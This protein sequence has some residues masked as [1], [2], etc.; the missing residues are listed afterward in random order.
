[1]LEHVLADSTLSRRPTSALI[2]LD[3]LRH[4]LS[5][6][7]KLIGP[8][9]KVMGIVK[10]NAYGH[11]LVPTAKALVEFGVNQLGVAFLEEGIALRRSGIKVP[12][13]VLGG[14]IG[15][16]VRHFIEHDL[17][18]AAASPYKVHQIDETARAMGTQAKVHLKVDT[19][20]ERLGV[21]WDNV[22]VLLDA[23]AQAKNVKVVGVFSHLVESEDLNSDYTKIQLERFH[24]ALSIVKQGGMSDVSVHLANSGGLLYHPDTWFDM[25]RPGLALYGVTPRKEDSELRLVLKLTSSIVYFKVI[26]EGS[27]VSY[28]RSWTAKETTRIVT[29]PIGYGDGYMRSMSNKASVIIRGK[30]C[31]VVG[32][33]TMDASMVNLGP[34]GTGYNGDNVIL[35]GEDSKN[36][37]RVSIHEL[38][39]WANTIPYEILTSIN[40]RVPRIY[41]KN[42]SL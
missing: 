37:T 33:I 32:K 10:A 14:L 40:T 41:L 16:Q 2:Q 13:L 7:K 12:I 9:R 30:R 25:V 27:S 21:H 36:G 18:M 31:P 4:N 15:N 19:G 5:C 1:M 24:K 34:N 29:I 23:I 28:N 11:G 20:M 38:A 17:Q 35:L 26:R 42:E 8:E 22:E 6:I 39:E 3:A